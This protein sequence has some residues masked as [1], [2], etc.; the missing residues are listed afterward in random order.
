IEPLDSLSKEL[1]KRYAEEWTSLVIL[2]HEIVMSFLGKETSTQPINIKLKLKSGGIYKSGSL[3][4]FFGYMDAT[5]VFEIMKHDTQDLFVEN[6]RNFL[7]EKSS[8]N[9]D[10]VKTLKETPELF[11]VMNNGITALCSGVYEGR[12]L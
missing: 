3:R 9:S 11:F 1:N 8:V 10:I 5:E 7:V 4:A 2:H 6:I 12:T